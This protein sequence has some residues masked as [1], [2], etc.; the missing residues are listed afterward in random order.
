[1]T[2]SKGRPGSQAEQL[3]HNERDGSS[4]RERW[5]TVTQVVPAL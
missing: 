4:S 2:A 3:P 5:R 1:M